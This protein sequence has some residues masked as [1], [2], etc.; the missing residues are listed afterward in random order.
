MASAQATEPLRNL[1]IRATAG[2]QLQCLQRRQAPGEGNRYDLGNLFRR[3]K[4]AIPARVSDSMAMLAPSNRS[5]AFGVAATLEQS[6][7]PCKPGLIMNV[8]CLERGA[9]MRGDSSHSTRRQTFRLVKD[10]SSH[11]LEFVGS[12]LR[13][14]RLLAGNRQRIAHR[15]GSPD[16]EDDQ[17]HRHLALRQGQTRLNVPREQPAQ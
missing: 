10:R 4:P 9:R 5:A 16:G 8:G 3:P 6:L 7:A 14:A 2:K 15:K 12:A 11:D 13:H 17:H 1:F